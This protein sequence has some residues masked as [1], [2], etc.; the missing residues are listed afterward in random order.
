MFRD[1]RMDVVLPDKVE[2]KTFAN[3]LYVETEGGNI[4]IHTRNRNTSGL[5]KDRNLIEIRIEDDADTLEL[6]AFTP[7]TD[8]FKYE[9]ELVLE[10]HNIGFRVHIRHMYIIPDMRGC[11]LGSLL[12]D[13]LKKF[14]KKADITRLSGRIK[15]S[16]TKDFLINQGFNKEYMSVEKIGS[17]IDDLLPHHSVVIGTPD[18]WVKARDMRWKVFSDK[19]QGVSVDKLIK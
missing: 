4:G 5:R 3:N 7:D 10:V 14:I 2:V 16:G 12:T 6:G 11:G 9:P 15:N 13:V 18:D 17:N 8:P 1:V 19:A